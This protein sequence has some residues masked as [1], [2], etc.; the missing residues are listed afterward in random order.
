MLILLMM[1]TSTGSRVLR[2]IYLHWV[3]ALIPK[4]DLLSWRPLFSVVS[5][6]LLV[7]LNSKSSHQSSENLLKLL[8][9]LNSE[10]VA[11]YACLVRLE[12]LLV[13]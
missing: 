10:G 9:I 3:L 13:L 5:S 11:V 7:L 12:V 8:I 2:P 4:L 6:S 1:T